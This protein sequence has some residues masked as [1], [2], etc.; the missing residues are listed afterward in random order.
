[1][2][3]ISV[4]EELFLDVRFGVLTGAY[5]PRQSLDRAEVGAAYGCKQ[6]VVTDAF[7][8]LVAESYLEVPKRGQY[9]VRRWTAEEVED[10]FDMRASLEGL[11]ADKAAE[12][13]TEAEIEH[14]LSLVRDTSGMSFDNPADIEA[15]THANLHFHAE[16]MRMSRVAPLA[17]MA[18]TIVPNA[19]HRRIVWSQHAADA[20]QSFRMH[21]KIAQAIAER[22]GP[23][24]RLM[25]R[26]DVYSA[27]EATLAA[28]AALNVL[29]VTTE[30]A[31]IRRFSET[32]EVNGRQL[33]K[34]TREPSADGKL[35]PFG[36]A[37]AQL[38]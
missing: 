11:A 31:V 15:T 10:L 3:D 16:V 32:W 7:N 22:S 19:L 1:V 33:A 14:L 35:V 27:R 5:L 18:R 6:G 29:P 2:Q 20:A 36:L 38:G 8:T 23:M 4:T 34:G 13:A 12:R 17:E 24:A 25:M 26:E 30:K 21:G 37:L 9:R 28:I